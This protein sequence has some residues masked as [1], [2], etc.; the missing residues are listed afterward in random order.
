MIDEILN[1]Q[2][3]RNL[4][5]VGNAAFAHK[6]GLHISAVEKN[7]KSY[8][9]IDPATVGN[10]RFLLSQI[11][12]EKSNVVNKLKKFKINIKGKEKKN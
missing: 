10:E 3:L 8:E 5:F 6:G 2:S 9:H 1:R 7:P 11:N 12:Q 4:P